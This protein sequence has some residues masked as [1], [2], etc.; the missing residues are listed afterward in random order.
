VHATCYTHLILLGFIIVTIFGEEYKSWSSFLCNFL[1]IL[2]V[3]SVLRP[4]IFLTFFLKQE[5][6]WDPSRLLSNRYRGLFPWGKKW[7]R[8]EADQHI[9]LVPRSRMRGAIPP[10][11]QYVFMSWCLN[12]RITLPFFPQNTVGICSSK[13][14]GQVHMITKPVKL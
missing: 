7:P 4:N 10:L 5:R 8:R 1:I 11:S 13:V 9:Y 3:Y 12:A 14:R 2:L 6:F